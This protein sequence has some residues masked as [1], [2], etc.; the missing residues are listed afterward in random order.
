MFRGRCRLAAMACFAAW[1]LGPVI[2]IGLAA[3]ELDHHGQELGEHS[4]AA[5][6]AEAF[7]HGHA[8]E[9]DA[10]DHA[11]ELTPPWFTPSRLGKH[12]KAT[13]AA[14]G[15][16]GEFEQPAGPCQTNTSPPE[17][18]VLAPPDFY[19]LCILRL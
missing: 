19:S 13:P 3:H 16:A 9:G 17:P 5:Q 14:V 1:A 18:N 15:L 2:G 11:H 12:S 8:H 4:H 6:A 10:G 7:L